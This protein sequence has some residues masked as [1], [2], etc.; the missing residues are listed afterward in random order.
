VRKPKSKSREA[1]PGSIVVGFDPQRRVLGLHSKDKKLRLLVSLDVES[2]RCDI[3]LAV[4]KRWINCTG[5]KETGELELQASRGVRCAAM[6]KIGLGVV[7][8]GTHGFRSV[9]TVVIKRRS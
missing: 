1:P 6:G 5:N 9:K 8:I 2:G 4:G 7:E 3:S